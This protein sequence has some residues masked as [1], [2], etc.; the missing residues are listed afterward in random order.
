MPRKP[1]SWAAVTG[2]VSWFS[3]VRCSRLDQ[4]GERGADFRSHV[5]P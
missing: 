1:Q 4:P 3:F 2:T 5:L